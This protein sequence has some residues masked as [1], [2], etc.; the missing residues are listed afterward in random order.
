[1]SKQRSTVYSD[2]GCDR[3]EHKI[4]SYVRLWESGEIS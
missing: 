3:E 4:A 1:M 2:R